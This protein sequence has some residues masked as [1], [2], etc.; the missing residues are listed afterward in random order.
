MARPTLAESKNTREEISKVALEMI[1]TR[2]LHA[3]SYQ[4]VADRLDI[5]KASIHYHYPS[6]EDLALDLIGRAMERAKIWR[7][8]IA[9]RGLAPTQKIEA[10]FDYFAT[11][12]A[13][14]TRIC[15]CAAL[16]SEWSA[17]TPKMRASVIQHS[18]GHREWLTQVIEEGRKTGEFRKSSSSAPEVAQFIY[19]SIYGSLIGARLNEDFGIFRTVTRQ[20]LESI[21]NR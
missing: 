10:F 6:K 3:F 19:S 1:Q 8:M 14:G 5:R 13:N 18:R 12:S 4:D 20:L 21:Q 2:G 16:V 17:L 11:V 15:P 7:E 9:E